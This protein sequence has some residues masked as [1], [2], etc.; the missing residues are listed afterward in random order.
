ML[1]SNILWMVY[2]FVLGCLNCVWRHCSVLRKF[3]FVL[4]RKTIRTSFCK[5]TW[6]NMAMSRLSKKRLAGK[7]AKKTLTLDEKIWWED[8]CLMMTAKIFCLRSRKR[9][10]TFN[11]RIKSNLQL[12][13][14]LTKACKYFWVN[15]LSKNTYMCTSTYSL[16]YNPR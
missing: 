4:K 5:E 16:I 6:F 13:H 3:P 1:L 14:I 2:M 11:W 10:R 12:K 8:L 15:S 9:L 7:L